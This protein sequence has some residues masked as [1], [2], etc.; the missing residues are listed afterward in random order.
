MEGEALRD[1]QW[2]KVK[3]FVPGGRKGRRSRA[4][5]GVAFSMRC[6]G[7][8]VPELADVCH[9]GSGGE[10]VIL[11]RHRKHQHSYDRFAYRQR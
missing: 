4:A 1:D 7:W 11:P 8:R 5:T 10:P 9:L 3:P 2:E 6:C